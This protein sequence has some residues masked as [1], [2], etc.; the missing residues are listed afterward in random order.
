MTKKVVRKR[1]EA[2]ETSW[3][4][5]EFPKGGTGFRS[6]Y[7][8]PSL[9]VGKYGLSIYL[10]DL[11][12]DDQ[13]KLFTNGSKIA[14]GADPEGPKKVKADKKGRRLSIGGKKLAG[15]LGLEIGAVLSGS[16]GEV[17]G[18]DGWIFTAK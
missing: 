2:G 4:E 12:G 9:K 3:T 15:Q 10:T 8:T 16:K 11:K 17:A 7:K 5:I 6:K 13:V 14:I 18:Q 1:T